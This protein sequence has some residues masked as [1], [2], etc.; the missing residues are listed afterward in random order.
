MTVIPD[1]ATAPTPILLY[2]SVSDEP[3]AWIA[4]FTVRPSTFGRH[5]DTIGASGREVVTVSELVERRRHGSH[6]GREVVITFDDGFAD[7]AEG[8]LPALAQHGFSSTLYLATGALT[9]ARKR[10]AWSPLLAV[11]ML[12]WRQLAELESTGVELGSHGVTH[13]QLDLLPAGP[14]LEELRHSKDELE[15]HL[16]HAVASFAYP[17]GY[18]GRRVERLTRSAGFR[19]ACGV[20][21]ALSPA[22]DDL[23]LIARLTVRSTT[24]SDELSRWLDADGPVATTGGR[25]RSAAWRSR[26]RLASRHVV[27][28]E[29]P[30]EAQNPSATTR[31]TAP[32]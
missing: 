26:R 29:S 6:T 16:G 5:L 22:D 13:R 12:A 4:P 21:N 8:A 20:R 3:A 25:W 1:R 27:T 18:A 32:A 10:Q 23:F 9:G 30:P 7:F 11:P 31:T 14:V 28:S 2:H 19:S 17:H 24:S 15:A